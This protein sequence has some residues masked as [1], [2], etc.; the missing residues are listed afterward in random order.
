MERILYFEQRGKGALC[1]L[2]KEGAIAGIAVVFNA[3]IEMKC[4]RRFHAT[5]SWPFQPVPCLARA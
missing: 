5:V 4:H 3:K 2:C 1:V